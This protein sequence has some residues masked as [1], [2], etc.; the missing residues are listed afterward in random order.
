[1]NL[2]RVKAVCNKEFIQILRDPR[3]LALGLGIPIILI[4]L[5][6]YGLSLDIKHV[7]LA[8][9]DRDNTKASVDFI[10][11]FRDSEYFKIIGYYDNYRDID[12]LINKGDALMA[13]V[14]PKHF[15][16]LLYTNQSVPVQLVLDGS[17]SNTATI[18]LG[19]AK[20]VINTYNTKILLLVSEASGVI[21]AE[22]IDFRPR[23]WFNQSLQ[24][25]YFIVPGL[26]AI[27]I[28]TIA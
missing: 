20:T 1:M 24:S 3:S 21:N 11:N 15:S 4:V 19:Y 25:K 5:F 8:I 16:R 23:I 7:P 27:I 18:A 22:P 9:W 10:L 6:G 2:R 26:I 14:I 13:M 12:R 17:D 28:T